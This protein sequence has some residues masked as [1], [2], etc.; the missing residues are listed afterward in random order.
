[1]LRLRFGD[2]TRASRSCTLPVPTGDP[3][4]LAAAARGLLGAAMP[5][6]E[7]R[8]ITLVGITVTNLEGGGAEQLT[9]FEG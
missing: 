1:M 5:L 9:L 6:I 2:Y 7:R 8:G 4:P 3:R